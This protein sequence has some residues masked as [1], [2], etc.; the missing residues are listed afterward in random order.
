MK[1]LITGAK[2]M[3]A[4]DIVSALEPNN[5]LALADIDEFDICQRDDVFSFIGLY[6]PELVIH[7]AAYTNVDK[8]ED[9]KELVYKIN[10][11]GTKNIAEA[12]N[13]SNI[14]ML[15]ISTDYVFDGSKGTPY[16]TDDDCFLKPL[17][18]YGKSKLLGEEHV[19][20]I[21]DKYFIVRTSWLYGKGGK[22]FVSTMLK[23]AETHD[24]VRVVSDQIGRPTYAPH[25]SHAIS[26]LIQTDSY[27]VYHISN[28]GQCSW[29]E[30]AKEIFDMADID[31]KVEPVTSEQ[32][33][34]KALRPAYSVMD[35]TKIE[36]ILGYKM[37]GWQSGLRE[38]ID[39]KDS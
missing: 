15:Y 31:I 8:A 19:K 30:F 18:V 33:G 21:C 1:I 24:T 32:Y 4:R 34:I 38:Y 2:G 5:E 9:E 11:K 22:N 14:K 26:K 20:N 7:C 35:L 39:K 28:G 13:V 29:Y 37:P 6:R 23:L 16:T 27:G 10:G 3:L 36:K 25:L 17:N 12:C